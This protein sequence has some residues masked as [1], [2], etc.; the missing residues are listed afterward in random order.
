MH[1]QD[2]LVIIRDRYRPEY[3][4]K[5]SIFSVRSI[6]PVGVQ[7]IVYTVKIGYPVSTPGL[8][9]EIRLCIESA[10]RD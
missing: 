8:D 1:I 5:Y 10:F 4:E 9:T 3:S 2:R 6:Q 7:S